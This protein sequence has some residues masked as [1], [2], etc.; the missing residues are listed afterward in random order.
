M[1]FIEKPE[2]KHLVEIAR[3]STPGIQQKISGYLAA[4][5]TRDEISASL[6]RL[7]KVDTRVAK[8]VVFDVEKSQEWVLS[9]CKVL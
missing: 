9:N 5:K 6:A 3:L 1:N 4:G 2:I 8:Q 7:F